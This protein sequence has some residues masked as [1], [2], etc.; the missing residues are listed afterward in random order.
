MEKTA[1]EIG[2]L[3]ALEEAG[4]IEKTAADE[5]GIPW[6]LLGGATL[7]GGGLGAKAMTRGLGRGLGRG[8]KPRLPRS[9]PADPRMATYG[10]KPAEK[11]TFQGQRM[12]GA[13]PGRSYAGGS[14]PSRS[15]SRQT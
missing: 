14:L 8:M 10:T 12:P 2:V 6:W 9:R 4:L 5:D 1:Y 15:Y 13:I 7:L 11:L 3:L